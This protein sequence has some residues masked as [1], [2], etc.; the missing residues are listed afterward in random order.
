VERIRPS[1]SRRPHR[2]CLL[3]TAVFVASAELRRR[4]RDT[5][6]LNRDLPAGAPP[7]DVPRVRAAVSLRLVRTS[8]RFIG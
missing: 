5:R 1:S 2:L 4:R 3:G 7:I 6:I 8:P